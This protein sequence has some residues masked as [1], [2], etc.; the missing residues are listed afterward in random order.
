MNRLQHSDAVGA[1]SRGFTLVELAIALA[2]LAVLVAAG[3]PSFGAA[4]ARHR[5]QAAAQ[6]LQ[7][8]LSLARQQAVA[9][10]QSAHLSLQPGTQWCWA[11][12]L[13]VAVDCRNARPGAFDGG[14]VLKVVHADAHP[15]TT[16][17]EAAPMALD[18]RT[19]TRLSAAGQALFTSRHGDRLAVQL[20]TLGRAHLCAPAAPVSG[21]PA[22]PATAH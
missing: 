17:A 2:V 4:L 12:S 16:L 11:L 19:G 14:E 3:V 7:A 15:N 13:G 9:H 8:D 1:G 10:G 20:N 18:A 22:C 5:L 6:H 21:V